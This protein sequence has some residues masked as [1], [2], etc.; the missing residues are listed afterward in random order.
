M[1]NLKLITGPANP[2]ISVTDLKTY[3][4]ID[5]SVE[6]GLLAVM[7]AAAVKRLEDETSHKF[8]NQTWD[9]FL[10]NY[11]IK[12][13]E[14]WWDGV[15]E[16]AI[17]EIVTPMRNITFPLGVASSF[18]EFSSYSDSEVFNHTVSDYVFDSVGH[19]ARVGLKLGGVWPTTILR[20]VNA[21]RFRFV[22]GFGA[23]ETA[24]PNDIK[25]AV[26]EFVAHMYE[27]RGDQDA[28]KIVPA[29]VLTLIESYRRVKIGR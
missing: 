7:E 20:S 4:R 21:L 1:F 22:F 5:N 6:D 9:I 17:T 27:N 26:R 19:R 29:H 14:K 12:P 10:D 16:M 25:M 15:R 2:V 3:L 24:V 28:M 23:D 8:I 18:V 13:S 11:P